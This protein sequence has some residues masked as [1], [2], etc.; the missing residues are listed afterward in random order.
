M[1]LKDV[2]VEWKVCDLQ[3]KGREKEENIGNKVKGDSGTMGFSSF[4]ITKESGTSPVINDEEIRKVTVKK[5]AESNIN[6][7]E[8]EDLGRTTDALFDEDDEDVLP[9][10]E[11]VEQFLG[12][13]VQDQEINQFVNNIDDNDSDVIKDDEAFFRMVDNLLAKK[14]KFNFL[15]MLR[16]MY[17][18]VPPHLYK[19]KDFN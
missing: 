9:T 11:E 2:V 12:E 15:P 14:K 8:E 6:G 19:D 5:E 10:M 17:A 13:Q 7:K 3:S 4:E 16:L 1:P 18:G